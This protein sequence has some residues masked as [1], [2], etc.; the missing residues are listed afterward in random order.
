MQG[1][2]GTRVSTKVIFF[3]FDELEIPTIFYPNFV[4]ISMFRFFGI[5]IVYF[6]LN[7]NSDEISF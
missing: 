7:R 4:E 2:V 1:P 5:S 6:R 3:T